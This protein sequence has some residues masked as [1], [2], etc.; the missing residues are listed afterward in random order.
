MLN[1]RQQEFDLGCGLILV[2]ILKNWVYFVMFSPGDTNRRQ[3][4]CNKQFLA[5]P[6]AQAQFFGQSN[7]IAGGSFPMY[8]RVIALALSAQLGAAG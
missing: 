1:H 7:A 4:L 3:V 6:R 2:F 8:F 5:Y